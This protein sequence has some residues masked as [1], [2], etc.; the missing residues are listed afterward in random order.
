MIV[1]ADAS[2]LMHL[3]RIRRLQVVGRLFGRVLVPQT[4]WVELTTG[5]TT[6]PGLRQNLEVDWLETVDDPPLEKPSAR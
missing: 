3:T 5:R 6:T 1:V 2:P 4:V